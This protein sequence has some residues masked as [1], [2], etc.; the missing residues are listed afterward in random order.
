MQTA[1]AKEHWQSLFEQWPDVVKREGVVITNT[2]ENIPFVEFLV[3]E[4]LLLLERSGP[5]ANG[6][7]RAIVSYE[8]INAVKLKTAGDLAVFRSMGFQPPL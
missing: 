7:R 1:V 5:D 2:G 4:G 8:S 6:M 3:S